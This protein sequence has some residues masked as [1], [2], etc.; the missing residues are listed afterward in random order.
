MRLVLDEHIDPVIAEQLRERGHDVMAVA[1]V[2]ELRGRPD[3][4]VFD[5][6]T[7]DGRAVVTYDIG[8][9]L[10]L[11]AA[12]LASGEG[13]PGL[14]LVSPH[15]V[16]LGDRGHGPLLRALVQLLEAGPSPDALR[17][18]VIWIRADHGP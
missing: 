15:T 9:F 13:S 6:A 1:D 7:A 4:L 11:H 12:R 5:Q 10:K 18:R 2:P 17:D 16:P 3:E 14:V 8:D